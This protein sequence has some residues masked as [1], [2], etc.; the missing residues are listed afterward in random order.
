MAHH[1]P[2]DPS[3]IVPDLTGQEALLLAR[4]LAR[5][6]NAIWRIYAVDIQLLLAQ[7]EQHHDLD[8]ERQMTL[9]ED[10]DPPF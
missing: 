9:F 8:F 6:S 10:D 2:L 7:E 4:L 5:L 3:E 1:E